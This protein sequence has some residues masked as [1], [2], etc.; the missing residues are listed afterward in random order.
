M[1]NKTIRN[2]LGI[3]MAS[4]VLAACSTTDVYQDRAENQRKLE[5]AAVKSTL[6]NMPK[7]MTDLPESESA[8]YQTGSA[9][10]GNLAMSRAKARNAAYGQ[11]CVAAG[12]TVSQ[13]TQT[14]V[15][16]TG[17]SSVE[18]SELAIRSMCTS[19]DIT[20]AEVADEVMVQENNRYRTYVLV[21]LPIGEANVLLERKLEQEI[22]EKALERSD[23]AFEEIDAREE[24]QS[25]E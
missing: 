25:S 8:I 19:T 9:T 15:S 1:L 21:A 14:F 17:N 3:V 6:R 10:S 2:T 5:S 22:Q 12:G 11:I 24:A 16:D 7:W 20:G 18:N 23:E 4:A 13:Q